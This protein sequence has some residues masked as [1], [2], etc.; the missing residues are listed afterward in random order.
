M[1]EKN[2]GQ[3]MQKK[4]ITTEEGGLGSALSPQARCEREKNATKACTKTIRAKHGNS[5]RAHG[6]GDAWTASVER[7]KL[8]R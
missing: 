5:E 2:A 6:D 1:E 3:G 4:V 8:S 7:S